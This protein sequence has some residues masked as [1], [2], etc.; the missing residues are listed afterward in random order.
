MPRKIRRSAD[1]VKLHLKSFKASREADFFLAQ[2][3]DQRDEWRS[4]CN[5][6]SKIHSS[7][8]QLINK[9][10]NNENATDD[11]ADDEKQPQQQRRSTILLQ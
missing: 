3:G 5:Q 11:D 10:Q 8:K 6:K 4:Q 9:L 7:I 1:E 2:F